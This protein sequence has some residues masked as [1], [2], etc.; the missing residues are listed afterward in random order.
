MLK[1]YRRF[2]NKALK[3]R[4]KITRPLLKSKLARLRKFI[5]DHKDLLKSNNLNM[6]S[7]TLK[8]PIYWD[9]DAFIKE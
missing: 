1:D 4:N 7:Q 2:V 9:W 6:W 8:N 3:D 5:L